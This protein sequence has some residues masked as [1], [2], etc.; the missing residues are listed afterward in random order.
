M[1]ISLRWV[2]ILFLVLAAAVGCSQKSGSQEQAAAPESEQGQPQA[3]EQTQPMEQQAE[4]PAAEAE[5][6]AVAE[7]QMQ[8]QAAP[9]QESA[10]QTEE[11]SGTV[12]RTEDGVALFSDVGHFLVDGQQL[13][14]LVGKNV[15][16]TATMNEGAE[17][18]TISIVSVYVL[19]S[20]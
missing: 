1:K 15:K 18:P 8:E 6:P 9:G 7:E 11:I 14:E 3:M 10:A 4:M 2:F 5:Q 16:V 17:K 13:D 12:V 19:D 20:E